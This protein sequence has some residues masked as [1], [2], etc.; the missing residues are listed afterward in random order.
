MQGLLEPS[1]KHLKVDGNPL[2]RYLSLLDIPL[3]L[4]H[5]A[6]VVVSEF[7]DSLFF[8]TSLNLHVVSR[9]TVVMGLVLVQLLLSVKLVV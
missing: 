7:F 2:R 1:L 5:L 4:T 9:R 6:F 8:G 3:L